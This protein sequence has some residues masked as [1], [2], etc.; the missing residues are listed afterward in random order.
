MCIQTNS[1]LILFP[2][3]SFIIFHQ[4]IHIPS[5]SLVIPCNA[6]LLSPSLKEIMCKPRNQARI[7]KLSQSKQ[8]LD[9][10]YHHSVYYTHMNRSR[11][12]YI[13][14]Q[15]IIIIY[16]LIDKLSAT[17]TITKAKYSF[18]HSPFIIFSIAIINTAMETNHHALSLLDSTQYGWIQF[19]RWESS[20]KEYSSTSTH[21]QDRISIK[22]VYSWSSSAFAL[23]I[24][25]LF[26]QSFSLSLTIMPYRFLFE[27]KV[28]IKESRIIIINTFTLAFII[29]SESAHQWCAETLTNSWSCFHLIPLHNL[30]LSI[31]PPLIT[32]SCTI[33]KPSLQW[34][35]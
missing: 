26:Y 27:E 7:T 11:Q 23:F 8:L 32:C 6:T 31:I 25:I 14:I 21:E 29:K 12:Y 18:S 10:L 28:Q 19:C 15:Q 1:S 16:W 4:I 33:H 2:S 35:L 22:R 13:N 9:S 34:A 17:I 24:I 20:I 5:L 30:V 3:D